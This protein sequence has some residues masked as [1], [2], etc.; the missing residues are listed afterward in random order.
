MQIHWNKKLSRII[1]KIIKKIIEN[2]FIE[3]KGK[4][5]KTKNIQI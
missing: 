1:K 4:I 3:R 5:K 2:E